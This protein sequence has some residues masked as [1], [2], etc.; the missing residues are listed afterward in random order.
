M[1]I[2]DDPERIPP[3]YEAAGKLRIVPE[4]GVRADEDRVMER[5]QA[6][7]ELARRGR[8]DPARMSGSRR[9]SAVESL[10]ELQGDV[11]ESGPDIF[12]EDLVEF[13]AGFI[14]NPNRR[15]DSVLPEGFDAL[16]GDERVG[17]GD[18]D[19]HSAGPAG[20]PPGSR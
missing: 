11:G 16:P 1:R 2:D 18:T 9:D 20:G 19:Y 10:G 4:N 7:G 17:I 5:S 3:P 8:A 6:V 12:E 13:P 14:E 15:F